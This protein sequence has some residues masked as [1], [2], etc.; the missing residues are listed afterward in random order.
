II[1]NF[2]VPPGGVSALPAQP[3]LDGQIIGKT[4]A[5]D[6]VT[7]VPNQYVTFQSSSLYYPRKLQSYADQS[8][9]F[10]FSG[11]VLQGYDPPRRTTVPVQPFTLSARHPNTNIA[12][13]NAPGSFGDGQ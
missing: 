3:S 6:G 11:G 7:P 13:P 1:R 4:L 2:A 8:G 5:G 10:S 9:N 12:A